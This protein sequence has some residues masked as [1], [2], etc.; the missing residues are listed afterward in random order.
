MKEG[1]FFKL[2][3]AQRTVCTMAYLQLLFNRLSNFLDPVLD[4]GKKLLVVLI[5]IPK[6]L[7]EEPCKTVVFKCHDLRNTDSSQKSE[8][9]LFV[10]IVPWRSDW[11]S[12]IIWQW[13]AKSIFSRI[14]YSPSVDVSMNCFTDCTTS[15]CDWLFC[16]QVFIENFLQWMRKWL[17]WTRGKTAAS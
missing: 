3:E 14:W 17:Q 15:E 9:F 7:Q 10:E 13:K 8:F 11:S 1:H 4:I 5:E 2:G 16:A 12:W 6:R